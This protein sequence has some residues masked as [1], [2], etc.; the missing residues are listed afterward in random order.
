[1]A[2]V[3]EKTMFE[4]YREAEYNK[5]YRVIYYT[6]LTEHN[7]EYEINRAMAGEQY[8]DGFISDTEK[9]IAKQVILD[10]VTRLNAGETVSDGDARRL[11]APYLVE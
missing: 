5:R 11:L 7:K 10:L 9:E 1:M 2:N 4:I 8:L 6:E 3:S